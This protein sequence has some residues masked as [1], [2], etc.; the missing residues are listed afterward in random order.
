MAEKEKIKQVNFK[1]D[2]ELYKQF[3]YK[4]ILRF[5]KVKPAIEYLMQKFIND[6]C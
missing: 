6:E 2:E 5:G 4:A 1:L 3:K